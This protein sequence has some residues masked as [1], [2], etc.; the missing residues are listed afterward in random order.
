VQATIDRSDSEDDWVRSYYERLRQVTVVDAL[1]G[2]PACP[3]LP[4]DLDDPIALDNWTAAWNAWIVHEAVQLQRP[5]LKEMTPETL[6]GIVRAEKRARDHLARGAQQRELEG[7]RN[8]LTALEDRLS[9]DPLYAAKKAL[10]VP[11]LKPIFTE[12][13]IRPVVAAVEVGDCIR[14]SLRRGASTG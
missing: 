3:H 5:L 13:D 8:A 1:D 6:A 4:A 2:I 9:K 10:L 12:T 7:G 14:A 11:I